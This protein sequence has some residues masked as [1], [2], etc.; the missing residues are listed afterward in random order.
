M[1]HVYV[2]VVLEGLLDFLVDLANEQ[3][4]KYKN[5]DIYLA[6]VVSYRLKSLI[7]LGL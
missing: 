7:S 2:Q 6:A 4:T 1:V 5:Q 3:Q